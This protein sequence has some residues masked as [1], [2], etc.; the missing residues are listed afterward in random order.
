[1][2]IHRHNLFKPLA[3][4]LSRLFIWLYNAADRQSKLAFQTHNYRV[5]GRMIAQKQ[6]MSDDLEAMGYTIFY[7]RDRFIVR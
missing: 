3:F 7:E 5:V 2:K 4:L 6:R 1:M